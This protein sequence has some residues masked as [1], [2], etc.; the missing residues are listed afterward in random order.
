[1]R[2]TLLFPFILAACA[3]PFGPADDA[4]IRAA[5][6]EQEQAWDAGDIRGF[7]AAYAD[8]VC[9]VSPR[10]ITCGKAAVTANYERSYPDK[11][12][13]GDL[14]FGIQ[15]VLAAGHDHAWVT[16]TWAL[17]RTA[18]TLSGGFSLLWE[19]GPNGWRILRDHTY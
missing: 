13:M 5:M 17:H 19:R 14:A 12:A 18:D 11:Q 3:A 7:M 15:E 4:A 6:S 1:M 8:S 16:G 10:G 9:F 2:L